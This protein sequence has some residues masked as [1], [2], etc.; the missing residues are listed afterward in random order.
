MAS[1]TPAAQSRGR[2]WKIPPETRANAGMV[3]GCF[4][5]DL[6]MTGGWTSTPPMV[7]FNDRTRSILILN[8]VVSKQKV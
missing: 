7:G 3:L 1:A 2:L 8:N 4:F 5:A 6:T